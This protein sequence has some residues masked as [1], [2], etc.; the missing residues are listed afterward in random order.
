MIHPLQKN[1][2]IEKVKSGVKEPLLLFLPEKLRISGLKQ[3]GSYSCLFSKRIISG[4]IKVTQML[5]RF[6]YFIIIGNIR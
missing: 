3:Q 6:F 2:K 4:F 5:K 1:A